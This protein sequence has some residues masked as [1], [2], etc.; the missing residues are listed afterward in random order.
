MSKIA[1]VGAGIFGT[2]CALRL[3]DLGHECVLFEKKES[4]LSCASR[5]NQYR[6]HKGFHYPRGKETVNQLSQSTK[7]FQEEYGIAIN[8]TM[9]NIYALARE[10]SLVKH[11]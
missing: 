4:I 9:K 8:Y 5:V 11:E 6:F 2:T 1:I 3:A 10:K 7:R